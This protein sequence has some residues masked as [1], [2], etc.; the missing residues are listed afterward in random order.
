MSVTVKSEA[1]ESVVA[2]STD[3]AQGRTTVLHEG[4]VGEQPYRFSNGDA[5]SLSDGQLL[6]PTG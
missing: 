6:T 2:I 3:Q 5:I 1:I 4:T